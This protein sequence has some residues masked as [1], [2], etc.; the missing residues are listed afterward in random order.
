MLKYQGNRK[1][2]I[3]AAMI[4]EKLLKGEKGFYQLVIS[5]DK[6]EYTNTTG[7]MIAK[8]MQIVYNSY[9]ILIDVKYHWNPFSK[10]VASFDPSDPLTITL[11]A[12][13]LKRSVHSIVG[14][15]IH[16][17]T[18]LVDNKFSEVSFGHSSNNPI[19]KDNSAPYVLGGMAKKL[20]EAYYNG[21]F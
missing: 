16:E 3:R 15:L 10:M 11:N 14:S 4:A 17:I 20:S 1:S 8:R 6:Y 7:A 19:G 9:E 18:H 12:W 13:K 2:V 21:T 5:F